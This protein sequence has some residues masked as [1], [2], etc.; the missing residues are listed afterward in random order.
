MQSVISIKKY[1][2]INLWSSIEYQGFSKYGMKV[3]N[4]S[5]ATTLYPHEFWN[6]WKLF[7]CFT[8]IWTEN[9]TNTNNIQ[10]NNL[11]S[12]YKKRSAS[13]PLAVPLQSKGWKHRLSMYNMGQML[14][15]HKLLLIYRKWTQ[16]KEMAS[17]FTWMK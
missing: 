9:V 4:W 5:T 17:L 8:L 6:D 7:K 16:A 13:G 3:A 12:W 14:M 10:R 2:S 1:Y 11:P 15:Y